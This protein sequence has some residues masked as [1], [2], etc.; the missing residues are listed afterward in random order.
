[1]K[2][3]DFTYFKVKYEVLNQAV[4]PSLFETKKSPSNTAYDGKNMC[5]QKNQYMKKG[6][7]IVALYLPKKHFRITT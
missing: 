5:L 3:L 6:S 4:I 2:L 7:C 1:M